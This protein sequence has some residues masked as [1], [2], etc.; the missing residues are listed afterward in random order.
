MVLPT[1]EGLNSFHVLARPVQAVLWKHHATFDTETWD[2]WLVSLLF[3]TTF[4]SF[5]LSLP[6]PKSI[7]VA[8]PQIPL[9]VVV[10]N[11]CDCGSLWLTVAGN[12][13]VVGAAWQDW[14]WWWL[15]SCW[16]AA[17]GWSRLA[18]WEVFF[19]FF[20]P[21]QPASRASDTLPPNDHQQSW[22]GGNTL[23]WLLKQTKI[24]DQWLSAATSQ[25]HHLRDYEV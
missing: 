16:S 15:P 8:L 1:R 25:N 2:M 18:D 7:K 23:N 4:L 11:I 17:P 19:L 14:A 9:A 5:S 22:G 24:L 10:Q 12:H 6:P 13:V 20:I 21:S 3:I